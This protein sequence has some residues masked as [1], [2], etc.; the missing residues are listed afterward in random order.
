MA[1]TIIGLEKYDT[2]VNQA[3]VDACFRTNAAN[4]RCVAKN[5]FVQDVRILL[6]LSDDCEY[7]A[8]VRCGRLGCDL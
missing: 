4:L 7:S 5:V 8:A 2:R 1:T 3:D 6:V